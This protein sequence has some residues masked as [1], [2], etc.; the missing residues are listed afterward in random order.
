MWTRMSKRLSANRETKGPGGY[1][2]LTDP[3]DPWK[4]YYDRLGFDPATMGQ[5]DLMRL[6][7]AARQRWRASIPGTPLGKRERSALAKLAAYGVGVPIDWKQIK[8]CGPET[9]ER[10]A[11][12]GFMEIRRHDDRLDSYV[13]TEAGGEAARNL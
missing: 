9:E 6:S 3:N 1:P 11:A 4:K 7:E 5:E 8:P 12:R 10:L 2:I 13:L